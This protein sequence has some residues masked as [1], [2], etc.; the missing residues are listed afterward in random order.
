MIRKLV[1]LCLLGIALASCGLSQAAQQST[2]E[3]SQSAVTQLKD[4]VHQFYQDIL[5]NDRVAALD[6]VASESKNQFLNTHYDGLADFRIVAV[7]VAKSGDQASVQVERLIR[8]PRF[9]QPLPVTAKD[10]WHLSNGQWYFVVPPVDEIDTPFGKMKVD[11]AGSSNSPAVQELQQDIDKAYKNVD[12][13][14]YIRA[15]QKVAPPEGT[16]STTDGKAPQ[17]GAAT[18]PKT[19]SKQTAKPAAP[20]APASGDT[21]KPQQ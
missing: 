6:L 21:S 2:D 7:E 4:R 16:A 18:A 12:P 20:P 8:V 5:K 9:P 19:D 14:Q 17:A 3:E 10:T 15:L 11:P 13:D 1:Y